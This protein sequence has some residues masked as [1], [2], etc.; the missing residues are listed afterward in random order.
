VNYCE[1]VSCAQCHGTVSTNNCAPPRDFQGHTEV[2]DPGVGVHQAH[3]S[4]GPDH[5]GVPSR[6]VLC[7]DCHTVPTLANLGAAPH[8]DGT[9]DVTF[10]G[11]VA[12]K[13][14][15]GG[16]AASYDPTTHKCS[17]VYCHRPRDKTGGINTSPTWTVAAS[18][19]CGAC[20]N[21]P[22]ALPHMQSGECFKCHGDVIG[23]GGVWIN[24]ALHINGVVDVKH[25]CDS[26]HGGA[27]GNFVSS[28]PPFDLGNPPADSN[29][30]PEV[31]AHQPHLAQLGAQMGLV[32]SIKHKVIECSE[33][34]KVPAT[35]DAPGHMD[36]A[37]AELTFGPLATSGGLTPTLDKS[38]PSKP[39]CSNT[40][41]H[42]GSLCDGYNKLP[43]WNGGAAESMCGSCHGIPPAETRG[44]DGV[45]GGV[46]GM[47]H[48]SALGLSDC[49]TCHIAT[50]IKTGP[51]TWD[52]ANEGACHVNGKV[53][54][55]TCDN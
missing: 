7:T 31:G 49:P 43:Q 1:S 55:A 37:P 51:T 35:V 40:F 3:L 53:S 34:H 44:S 17:M 41:C 11:P 36:S 26:C 52:W 45:C 50:M 10:S 8:M 25:S 22:P 6:V 38:D 15:P 20:H 18:A 42:G 21:L 27:P 28:A 30:D 54:T 24:A 47:K 13:A 19:N 2:T 46:T 9:P 12:G 48:S 5:P 29:T 32:S 39:H 33:C 14:V 23:E 4:A 16:A